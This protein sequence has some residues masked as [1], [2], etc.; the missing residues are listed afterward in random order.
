MDSSGAKIRIIRSSPGNPLPYTCKLCAGAYT[1]L[2]VDKSSS[3]NEFGTF[4]I[5]NTMNR[6]NKI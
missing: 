2:F 5:S 6:E 1:L 4:V 3:A